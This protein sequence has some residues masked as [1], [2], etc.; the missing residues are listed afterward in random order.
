M[1]VGS[2][3]ACGGP[4][5]CASLQQTLEGNCGWLVRVCRSTGNHTIKPRI[6]LRQ[7]QA[8]ALCGSLSSDSVDGTM[9]RAR[10]LRGCCDPCLRLSVDQS[11]ASLRNSP[12]YAQYGWNMPR[13]A[14]TEKH[15]LLQ[16]A[17]T[18]MRR[19]CCAAPRLTSASSVFPALGPLS[20]QAGDK[21]DHSLL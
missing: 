2:L 17:A 21:T 8:E 10:C 12:P 5:N 9:N 11:K 19:G 14:K 18:N 1:Y 20:V 4:M 6:H 7:W 13:P 15:S 3:K 16:G